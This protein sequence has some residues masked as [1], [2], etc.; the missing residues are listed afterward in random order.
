MIYLQINSKKSLLSFITYALFSYLYTCMFRK[1]RNHY[2]KNSN[3]FHWCCDSSSHIHRLPKHIHPYLI[4]KLNYLIKVLNTGKSK[5]NESLSQ[6]KPHSFPHLSQS[7][8]PSH[9]PEAVTP[10]LIDYTIKFYVLS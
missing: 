10:E 1:A 5:V 7:Q 6:H 3:S 8:L 4:K 9:F 2:H